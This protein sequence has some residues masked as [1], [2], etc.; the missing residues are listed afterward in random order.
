MI[1]ISD[2]DADDLRSE[3]SRFMCYYHYNPNGSD[4][5]CLFCGGTPT[6]Y[7]SDIVHRPDCDGERFLKLLESKE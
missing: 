4:Y 5:S 2:D 7:R 1:T 3:L 6:P